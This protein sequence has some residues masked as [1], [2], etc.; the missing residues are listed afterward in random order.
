[1]LIDLM[2][3]NF[4]V[5]EK[6]GQSPTEQENPPGQVEIQGEKIEQIPAYTED[7]LGACKKTFGLPADANLP[8]ISVTPASFEKGNFSVTQELAFIVFSSGKSIRRLDLKLENPKGRYCVDMR[9][10]KLLRNVHVESACGANTVFLKLEAHR[11]ISNQFV[12]CNPSSSVNT[13]EVGEELAGPSQQQV[14]DSCKAALKT[15]ADDQVKIYNLDFAVSRGDRLDVPDRFAVINVTNAKRVTNFKLNLDHPDG[16]YCVNIKTEK[17]LKG[18]TILARCPNAEKKTA[19]QIVGL[20][21]DGKN[22]KKVKVDTCTRDSMRQ[23][24]TK[25]SE[26]KKAIEDTKAKIKE[27]TKDK[28]LT[29]KEKR[30]QIAAE[31]QNLKESRQTKNQAKKDLNNLNKLK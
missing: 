13:V 4:I 19:P 3:K 8:V 11:S 2:R 7:L 29:R 15:A 1:M 23:V 25:V 20:T 30:Q 27:I 17:N 21:L 5:V 12:G 18:L 22:V 6:D 16:R 14:A 9:A 24:E 26:A 10:E 28:K 31:K